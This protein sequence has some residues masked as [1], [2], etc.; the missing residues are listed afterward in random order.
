MKLLDPLSLIVTGSFARLTLLA[1]VRSHPTQES[2]KHNRAGGCGKG[3]SLA[4]S[5]FP[6]LTVPGLCETLLKLRPE[7]GDQQADA[8]FDSEDLNRFVERSSAWNY[9]IVPW[10]D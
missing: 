3:A 6:I 4:E 10:E 2:A 8:N 1:A 9:P 5:A 7:Q